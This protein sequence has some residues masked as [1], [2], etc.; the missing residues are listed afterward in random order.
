MGELS[1]QLQQ[2]IAAEINS[3]TINFYFDEAITDSLAWLHGE[4]K[5]PSKNES[6][7]S[8]AATKQVSKNK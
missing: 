7:N 6:D 2:S 5:T 8:L 1:E 4:Q 3:F